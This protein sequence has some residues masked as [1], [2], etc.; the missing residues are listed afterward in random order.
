MSGTFGLAFASGDRNQSWVMRHVTDSYPRYL[1][2]FLAN[3]GTFCHWEMC[4]LFLG[5]KI[6]VS[7]L[8]KSKLCQVL[9]K[10]SITHDVKSCYDR[11][12]YIDSPNIQLQFGRKSR[13]FL[14]STVYN[15]QSNQFTDNG[16]SWDIWLQSWII[17]LTLMRIKTG[18]I[19]C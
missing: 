2:P 15:L 6:F 18:V 1:Q 13:M 19:L 10:S 8:L 9:L 5:N 16:T 7:K 12:I 17:D 11:T 14:Q 4:S 3:M